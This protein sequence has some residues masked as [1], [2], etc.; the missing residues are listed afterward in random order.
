MS[1]D[2]GVYILESPTKD[3]K[4]KEYRVSYCNGLRDL[5]DKRNGKNYQV[6]SFGECDV[7]LNETEAL[8]EAVT[9]YK[10]YGS[11]IE[12]GIQF[13][14]TQYPFPEMTKYQ[15]KKDINEYFSC[16]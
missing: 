12:Y 9:Q 3:G 4:G 7:I 1:A 16:R 10:N 14:S 5:D 8:I 13:L 6:L 2:N 15:A 11:P